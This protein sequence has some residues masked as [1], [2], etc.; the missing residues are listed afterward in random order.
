MIIR[1]VICCV[2]FTL[3]VGCAPTNTVRVGVSDGYTG[4]LVRVRSGGTPNPI[5]FIGASAA[6]CYIGSIDGIAGGADFAVLPGTHAFKLYVTHMGVE[7]VGTTE[8]V[9]PA[10]PDL[11]LRAKRDGKRF[12]L[13]LVR[14]DTSEPV[15][16]AF[17]D[18]NRN[19]PLYLPVVPA[20]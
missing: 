10:G 1:L 13:T 9:V 17:V 20:K 19:V 2:A 18:A 12:T 7:F 4:Q 14:V 15:S 6:H 5:Q 16:S 3:A 11:E 8:I